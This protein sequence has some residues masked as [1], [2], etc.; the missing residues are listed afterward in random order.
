MAAPTAFG[1]AASDM[2]AEVT[3]AYLLD[4]T[5]GSVTTRVYRWLNQAQYKMFALGEWPELIVADAS[6]TTDGSSTYDLTTVEISGTADALFGKVI[7]RTVRFGSRN[8]EPRAKSFFNELDPNDNNSGN[9]QYFCQYNKTDF[10]IHPYSS[11]GDT[12]YFDYVKYPTTIAT[13]VTAAQISFENDRHDL[14]VEGAFWQAEHSLYGGMSWIT[15]RK[16]W[17]AEV[18][19]VLSLSGPIRITPKNIK[20]SW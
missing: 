20:Q 8:L 13:D 17:R 12:L 19:R 18:K 4:S 15:M 11:D 14:I 3:D 5:K 10:R 9:P 6:I 16:E 7:D 1:L 2:L